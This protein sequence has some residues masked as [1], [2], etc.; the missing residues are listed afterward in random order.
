MQSKQIKASDSIR[1]LMGLGPFMKA[2]GLGKYE[3]IPDSLKIEGE[4]FYMEFQ[5]HSCAEAEE[6][7][8]STSPVCTLCSGY[9]SGW[10]TEALTNGV[11]PIYAFEVECEA[12]GK[13]NCCKFVVSSV[14]TVQENVQNYLYRTNNVKDLT[15][16]MQKMN[17]VFV[18]SNRQQQ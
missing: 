4:N 1:K 3:M 12:T 7:S 17:S 11:V 8:E 9:A 14:S 6:W 18:D 2:I 13:T 10:I 16:I 5:V 15:A